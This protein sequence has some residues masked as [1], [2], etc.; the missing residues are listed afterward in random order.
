MDMGCL[1]KLM[2]IL[3]G[4]KD[5]TLSSMLQIHYNAFLRQGHT[6]LHNSFLKQAQYS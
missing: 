2:Y 6:E 5:F 1:S 4:L 3:W